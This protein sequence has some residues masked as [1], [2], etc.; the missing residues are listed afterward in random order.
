MENIPIH[1]H[2]G[3]DSN[4]L[5]LS[6]ITDKQLAITKPSGGTTIDS[7]ARTAINDIVD[8]LKALGL[9]N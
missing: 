3:I 8:K 6:D 4:K 7:Q 1:K 2:N 5:E 9:T